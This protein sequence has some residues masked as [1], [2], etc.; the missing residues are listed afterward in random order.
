MAFAFPEAPAAGAH[1]SGHLS[2][3]GETALIGWAFPSLVSLR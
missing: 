2:L 1:P 3:I